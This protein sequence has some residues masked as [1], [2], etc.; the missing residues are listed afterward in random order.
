MDSASIDDEPVSRNATNFVTA[1][2]MFANSA[3]R[4]ALVP[5]YALTAPP[6]A[7]SP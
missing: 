2:P 5:P 6:L 4:I 3:A 7:W 1:I